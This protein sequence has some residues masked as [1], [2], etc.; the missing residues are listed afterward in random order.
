MSAPR[1]KRSAAVERAVA[2]P[3]PSTGPKIGAMLFAIV[4]PHQHKAVV[5]GRVFRCV[6]EA[7]IV[8]DVLSIRWSA[9][10][11]EALLKSDC[12]TLNEAKRLC[13]AAGKGVD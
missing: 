7:A 8:N 11:G 13:R 12:R 2:V 9:F 10:A 6:R 5:S 4:G 1:E 3:R